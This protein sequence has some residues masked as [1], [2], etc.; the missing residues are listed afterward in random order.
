MPEINKKSK[1]NIINMK[2]KHFKIKSKKIKK[3]EVIEINNKKIVNVNV[4]INT[5]KTKKKLKKKKS[6]KENY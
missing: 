5:K 1:K 3:N 6:K 2:D 4:N